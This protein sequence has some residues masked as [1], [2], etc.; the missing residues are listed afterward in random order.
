MSCMHACIRGLGAEMCAHPLL[1]VTQDAFMRLCVYEGGLFSV[2]SCR[3]VPPPARL[4]FPQDLSRNTHT[5]H[6]V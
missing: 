1:F 6:A 3:S 4:T 5:A 2:T